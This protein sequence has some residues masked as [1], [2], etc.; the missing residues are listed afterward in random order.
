MV[1]TYIHTEKPGSV[2]VASQFM[3]TAFAYLCSVIFTTPITEILKSENSG[4][5][6]NS[7]IKYHHRAADVAK[8]TNWW[9]QK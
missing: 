4:S 2:Y 9:F 6:V 5:T 1:F 8:K 7:T 3:I